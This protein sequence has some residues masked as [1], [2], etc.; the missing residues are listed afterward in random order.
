MVGSFL[1]MNVRMPYRSKNDAITVFKSMG[2][3]RMFPKVID[4]A[5]NNPPAAKDRSRNIQVQ[6]S[7]CGAFQNAITQIKMLQTHL[8]SGCMSQFAVG[9]VHRQA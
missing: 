8:I 9:S 1:K 6:V 2:R 4:T 3:Y 5:E 7:R